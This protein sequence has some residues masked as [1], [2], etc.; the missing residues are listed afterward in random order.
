M[1]PMLS[2]I[3]MR[4]NT[5]PKQKVRSDRHAKAKEPLE[6]G[7]AFLKKAPTG[8]RDALGAMN[9]LRLPSVKTGMPSRFW[10]D[11]QQSIGEHHRILE[12]IRSAIEKHMCKDKRQ[13]MKGLAKEQQNFGGK[14]ILDLGDTQL[15]ELTKVLK[16]FKNSL[17]VYGCQ[18]K[19]AG[20]AGATGSKGGDGKTATGDKDKGGAP[21]KKTKTNK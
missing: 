12:K 17:H 11:Y 21:K 8:I 19:K 10:A 2:C 13:F 9:D 7:R 18:D 3:A 4:R 5:Y 6:R 15:A 14:D 20:K 16:A 1:N